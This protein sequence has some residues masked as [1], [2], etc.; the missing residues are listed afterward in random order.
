MHKKA[1]ADLRKIIK[2]NNVYLWEI[3]L[4]LGISEATMTR[5]FR[6]E[7]SEADKKEILAVI[8]MLKNRL[9]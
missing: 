1:N 3:A 5:R 9:E 7:M 4:F 2:E 8:K 6:V